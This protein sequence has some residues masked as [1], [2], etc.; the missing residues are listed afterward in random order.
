M[1]AAAVATDRTSLHPA[2][3]PAGR[4]SLQEFVKTSGLRSLVVGVSK[5][6]NAKVTVL[7]VS[8]DDGRPVL[9]VKAPMTDAAAAAVETEARMLLEL[10]RHRTP[11]ALK[12]VPSMVAT[13]EFDGRVAAL[14][15]T[16]PGLPMSTSYLR[17]RHS[18]RRR[19]VERDFTAVARWIAD[20]QGGTAGVPAPLDMGADVA[21]RLRSRFAGDPHL[22]G[23]LA[24]LAEIH[25]GLRRDTVPRTVVHGDFWFGNVLLQDGQVSGV[26]D[27]EA[28][29]MSGEPVRDLAR[30]AL[31]YA[32]Y[33]DCRTR[34]GRRVVG[35]PG[36][37]AGTWGAG[38]EYALCGSG[39]F[40]ELFRRFLGD[41]L[42]RL[43]A[44]A[45]SWRDVA[46]AGIAEVAAVTD[47]D[48]FA[49]LHLDLFRG[50]AP[51]L[52]ESRK[53]SGPN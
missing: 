2:A 25:A 15:T 43:G 34:R 32:L 7:L 27:W 39:W 41:G 20:L 51:R 22:A 11:M 16:V 33:L 14:M 12:T 21:I 37:V 50:L 30:F 18:S 49:S 23:D 40:P 26:V 52:A 38:I 42:R 35:H 53:D 24:V 13:L 9:A 31:M 1:T 6:P 28:G 5:D 10:G 48:R 36:L 44:S 19:K 46:L 17:W 8:P 4:P 3:A 45:A 29:A 47:D